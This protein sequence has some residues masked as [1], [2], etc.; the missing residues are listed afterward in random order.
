MSDGFSRLKKGNKWVGSQI[1]PDPLLSIHHTIPPFLLF[2]LSFLRGGGGKESTE[3]MRLKDGR[4]AWSSSAWWSEVESSRGGWSLSFGWWKWM[5][6]IKKQEDPNYGKSIW[7]CIQSSPLFSNSPLL[8]KSLM[9]TR[10]KTNSLS[11]LLHFFRSCYGC[12]RLFAEITCRTHKKGVGEK[13]RKSWKE[14]VVQQEMMMRWWWIKRAGGGWS[15]KSKLH[16]ERTERTQHVSSLSCAVLFFLKTLSV[17]IYIMIGRR[18][19]WVK[20]EKK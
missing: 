11:V 5:L 10:E 9:E 6:R 19:R 4:Q 13:K 12:T 14:Q 3:P 17:R 2:F 20:R 1:R 7:I 8:L 15:Q 18:G 16:T